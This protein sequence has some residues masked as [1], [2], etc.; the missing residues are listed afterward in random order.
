MD[1]YL[2]V[3]LSLSTISL[4]KELKQADRE[5]IAL[6]TNTFRKRSKLLPKTKL[7]LAVP[8]NKAQQQ[9]KH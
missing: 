2:T 4:L 1:G 8:N 6:L 5:R 9:A 3:K 7:C